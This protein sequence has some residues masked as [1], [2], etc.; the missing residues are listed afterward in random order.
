MNNNT[1]DGALLFAQ[2]AISNAISQPV[3]K[4]YFDEY[5]YTAEKLQEGNELYQKAEEAHKI[6]KKEYG[7]QYEATSDLDIAKANADK[8]YKRHLKIA[9]I[10]LGNEPG[11][12]N[13]LQLAGIR[14]RTLSGWLSQAKAFYAN[15]I[16][17]PAV[18]EALGK[19]NITKEKLEAGQALIL[20]CED[21]Y[22]KQLKEKGEAQTAT[23]VRDNAVDELDKWMSE[24]TGIARIALEEN[25]QYLEMLGIVEPS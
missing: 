13:A 6:Q 3:L 15:G 19:Y 8:V 20:E 21:K 10:A 4:P 23:K 5:G 25:P 17:D 7:D 11:P 14:L 16:K 2:N 12:V 18:L 24:F 22:N 1:I 9:R